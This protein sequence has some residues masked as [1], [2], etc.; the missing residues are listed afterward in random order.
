VSVCECESACECVCVYECASLCV[1]VCVC[2]CVCIFNFFNFE[3]KINRIFLGESLYHVR[4]AQFVAKLRIISTH[5]NTRNHSN[6]FVA[7]C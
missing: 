7:R 4:I 6:I 3:D 5:T 2:A 1:C